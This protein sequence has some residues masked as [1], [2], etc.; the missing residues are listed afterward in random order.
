MLG[1]I[2]L[3][4]GIWSLAGCGRNPPAAFWTWSADDSTRVH[5]AVNTWEAKLMSDF[6]DL[7]DSSD[8]INYIPDTTK[9]ALRQ[10]LRENRYKHRWFPKTF[11]R[12]FSVDSMVDSAW[13]TKDTTVEVRLREFLTGVTTITTDSATLLRNPDT[14]IGGMHFQV[15][16]TFFSPQ[17]TTVTVNITATCDRELFLVPMAGDSIDKVHRT[18]WVVKRISGAGRYYCPDQ[19]TAPYIGIMQF[20]TSTGRRDTFM[21]RPDTIHMGVQRLYSPDS[22]LTYTPGDT[23]QVVMSPTAIMGLLWWDPP[24]IVAFLHIGHVR[25][26]LTILQPYTKFAFTAADTG[27]KQVYIELVK[28]DPLTQNADNFIS[29]MWAIPMKVVA[30]R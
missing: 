20:V 1:A 6:A 7:A 19:A 15:Y 14:V 4:A 30:A 25:R 28:R 18:D 13:T 17:E 8:I 10:T 9:K 3:A 21:L 2:V 29:S 5:A 12:V 16:D 26:N 24:D 27:M 22:L 11:G 23:I